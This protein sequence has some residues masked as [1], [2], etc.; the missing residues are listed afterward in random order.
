MFSFFF[1]EIAGSYES[2]IS[3]VLRNLHTVFHSG[4]INLHSYQRCTYILSHSVMAYS[5]QPRG[6]LCPCDF[7]GK[8][9]G[10]DCNFLL[11]GL[12]VCK[13]SLFSTPSPT[14]VICCLFD[15]SHSDRC[16]VI[17]KTVVLICISLK[18]SD[19]EYLIIFC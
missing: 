13:G 8:N 4:C 18:I 3:N 14:L 2:S 6:F 9:T 12:K 17:Y 7:P 11:Q 1:K 10:V 15:N 5:L 16:E 19:G